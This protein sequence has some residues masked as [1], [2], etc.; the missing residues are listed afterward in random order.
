MSSRRKVSGQMVRRYVCC[1]YGAKTTGNEVEEAC[2]L[3][4]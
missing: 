3:D 2:M 4:A 1:P